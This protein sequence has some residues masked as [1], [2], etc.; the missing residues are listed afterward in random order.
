MRG[1]TLTEFMD[2][3][4]TMGGPEKEFVF[5]D[6]L[7]FLEGARDDAHCTLVVDEYDYAIPSD[8]LPFLKTYGFSE[9]TQEECVA[10]FEKAPIFRGLTLYE[11]EE[12]IQV[13]VG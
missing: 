11:T 5:R 2:D 1:N 4:L 12:E 8:E 7:Y 13:L 6:R 3:L 9:K 10:A